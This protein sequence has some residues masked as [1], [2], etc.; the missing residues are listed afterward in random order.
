M[1]PSP[2]VTSTS[3]TLAPHADAPPTPPEERSV[4]SPTAIEAL[5]EELGPQLRLGGAPVESLQRF[6]T[7]I[8]SIDELT[9]GGFPRGRLSEIAGPA[10]SGRT[11]LALALLAGATA[12]GEIASLVDLADA[13]D[14]AS[15]E[16]AGVA[17]ERVL[18]VRPPGLKEAL[19]CTERL[20]DASGFALVLL[21]LA[22]AKGL[23]RSPAPA[24]WP[25]LTRA[26]S[27]TGTGLV[28]LS[29]QRIAGS[30]TELAMELEPA[31]ARFS[32]S[33]A[34]L[35]GLE[36]GIARFRGGSAGKAHLPARQAYGLPSS[37]ITHAG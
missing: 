4:A 28:V 29:H 19:T 37:R 35:E 9:E 10:S 24:T 21:D 30:Y 8:A 20:I 34:L 1:S 33:P 14:P 25:R 6:A 3:R 12:S 7:G 16:A 26:A 23:A 5:L 11:S 18:W 15:A 2:R 17:L 36:T 27:S 31:R 32:T 13:F 22:T